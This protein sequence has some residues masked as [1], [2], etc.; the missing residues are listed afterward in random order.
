MRLLA[1]RGIAVGSGSACSAGSAEPSHV[2]KAMGYDDRTSRSILRISFGRLSSL[3]DVDAF[4]AGL[5][6]VLAS[7]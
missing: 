5:K 4:V 7:Y 6:E 2:L 3:A 1:E